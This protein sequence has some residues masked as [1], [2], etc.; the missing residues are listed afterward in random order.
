MAATRN[1]R[2]VLFVFGLR[3]QDE[4]FHLVHYLAVASCRAVLQPDDIRFHCHELPYGPYWD[5]A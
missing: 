4:P 3:P 1:P 2:I 5:L